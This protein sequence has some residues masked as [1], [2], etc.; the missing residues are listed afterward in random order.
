MRDI[1]KLKSEDVVRS[2][3]SYSL[4]NKATNWY[5]TELTDFEKASLRWMPL[6]EGWY[7]QLIKRW[8]P[9]RA[10]ALRKMDVT[11]YT[12]NDVR[13]GK[14]PR[15]YAQEIMRHSRAVGRDELFDQLVKVR[16]NIEPSLRRDVINPSDTTTLTE[17]L[18]HLDLKFLDW[19]DQVV[20]R[21]QRMTTRQQTQA[22][23]PTDTTLDKLSIQR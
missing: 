20:S 2:H 17:F 15:D 18:E 5:D 1:T 23:E 16:D 3:M 12:W 10:E 8:K 4:R 9:P 19:Q 13:I 11:R 21:E 7:P 14:E 6:E 22:P